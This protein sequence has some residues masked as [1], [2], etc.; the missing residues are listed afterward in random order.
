VCISP[1]SEPNCCFNLN[2]G[3]TFRA[4]FAYFKKS[5]FLQCKL[6]GFFVCLFGFFRRGIGF[7]SYGIFLGF[8]LIKLVCPH[9]FILKCLYQARIVNSHICVVGLSLFPL[10]DFS[11]GFWNCSDSVVFFCFTFEYLLLGFQ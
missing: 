6:L 7:F 5:I 8:G 1:L 2:T 9:H 11:I 4:H 3:K 10:Y